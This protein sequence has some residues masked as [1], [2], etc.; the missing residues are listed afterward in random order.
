M[1]NM[2][3]TRLRHRFGMSEAQAH[4][5]ADLVFGGSRND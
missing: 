4:L 2:R 1:T 3:I 5:Y